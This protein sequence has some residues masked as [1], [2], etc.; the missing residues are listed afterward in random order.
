MEDVSVADGIELGARFGVG[1]VGSGVSHH[2]CNQ[3]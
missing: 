1:A 3:K 2:I